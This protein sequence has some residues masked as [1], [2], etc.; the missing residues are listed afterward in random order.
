[1]VA[2]IE[3]SLCKAMQEIM[4]KEL[5]LVNFI[6]VMNTPSRRLGYSTQTINF[7]STDL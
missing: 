1:M 4:C 3:G 6:S 2:I 7:H 5:G